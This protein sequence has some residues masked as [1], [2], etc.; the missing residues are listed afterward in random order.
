MKKIKNM[1]LSAVFALL[2]IA[3]ATTQGMAGSMMSSDTLFATGRTGADTEL[4]VGTVNPL[5]VASVGTNTGQLSGLAFGSDGTLYAS[6]G[7]N[8]GVNRL[9]TVDTGTGIATDVGPFINGAR[10]ML[11][12][13]FGNGTLY[14]SDRI[15]LFAI[16]TGTGEATAVGGFVN[17]SNDIESIA[18]DSTTNTLYGVHRNDNNLYSISTLTGEATSLGIITGLSGRASGLG[19]DS[20]G[21]LYA[22]IGGGSGEIFSIDTT[23]FAATLVGDAHGGS[24]SDI[25]FLPIPEPTSLALVLLGLTGC[26]RIRRKKK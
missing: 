23:T 20:E 19:V 12:L 25:A 3:L 2:A 11:D 8:N 7:S 5:S 1:W 10:T 6:S 14:G 9:L 18:Y 15:S 4:L 16:N 13:T 24:V 21:H 17:G 26:S 22:S